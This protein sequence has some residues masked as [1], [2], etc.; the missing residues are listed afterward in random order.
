MEQD[1]RYDKEIR[2]D[3]TKA[4]RLIDRGS[5]DTSLNSIVFGQLLNA[6]T[7]LKIALESIGYTQEEIDNKRESEAE[8]REE[9]E[10]EEYETD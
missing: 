9:Q 7:S 2:E 6:S 3:L 10:E 1:N 8:E 4:L 5:N